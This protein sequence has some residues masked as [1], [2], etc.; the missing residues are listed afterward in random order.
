[1][2]L[3]LALLL[4]S[5]NPDTSVTYSG[6]AGQVDVRIPRIEADITVDGRLD[7]AAWSRAAILS[8]FSQFGPSDG[9]P[10]NDSTQVLVWYSPS[11]MYF[12]I[13]AFEAH[14]SVN[15]TMA[16]RDRIFSDDNIQLFLG[17]FHDG[18][19]AS[20]FAV[21]PLGVQADG[22][23]VEAVSGGTTSG[24][25]I[26]T[27]GG[28]EA[29]DLSP[30]FVFQSRGHLT[31]WGYEIEVRIPFKSLRYQAGEEQS[32]GLN[33]VRQVKH[34]GFE[35]SWTP[36]RRASSSFLGQSGT[37]VGLTGLR[38][39]LVMDV[40]PELTNRVTGA[41]A[42]GGYAYDVGNPQLGG[43]V[44]WGVSNNLTLN[45]S[46][47]PDFSQVE[48]DAGQLGF[49]PRL[50]LF[51]PEKRPFFLEGIEQFQVP[52]QLIY[53]RRIVQPVAAAKLTGKSFGT[54]LGF[55]AAVDDRS[56]SSTGEDNPTFVVFRAQR[57]VGHQSRLGFA[58]TD[59]R[60]PR[61]SNTLADIDG[62]L[63]F[64]GIY[65]LQ[66]QAAASRTVESG[67][68]RTAPLWRAQFDIN[69][70]TLG[71]TAGSTGI[72]DRFRADAGFIQRTGVVQNF[73]DPRVTLYGHPGG[74][75]QRLNADLFLTANWQYQN[76]VHGRRV[77]D[78][79]VHLNGGATLRGGWNFGL[80]IFIESFGYDPSLYGSYALEVPRAGGGLDTIPFTGQPTINNAEV[81]FQASTPQWKRFDVSAFGLKGND[82]NFFEWAS[83]DL[84]ILNV[85]VNWRPTDRMR[86]GMTYVWQQVNRRTDHTTVSVGRIPRLKLEYQIARPIFLRLVAQYVQ[87]RTDSLH[88]DSR[89]GAPILIAGP[90]GYTRTSVQADN[91]L[92]IDALF[93]YQPIPGTVVF[94]GY[95]STMTEGEAFHF[96]R[97]TRVVDGFFAK[98]SYL[99]RL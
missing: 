59:R 89:T 76:F 40:N 29:P 5:V 3:A 70:R 20:F 52:N 35:D 87:Q 9:V 88:D 68:A 90:G 4:Q 53:T 32:W 45:G 39:G 33:V 55:L 93:S 83:A 51:F 22:A 13:R 97:L 46:V 24:I 64:S 26:A 66:L 14:G 62:R 77:Q 67:T 21:N 99:F 48:S 30:D 95:G 47:K 50:A 86:I 96:D 44:R 79:K 15:A 73:L 98:V 12:G 34:S 94:A 16:D 2:M 41:P 56:A 19:Q 58:A 60:D 1:M 72:S 75:L 61:Y 11:A 82:E 7:E 31:A 37:L 71:F 80:G 49:D 10:A 28:R 36:A 85:A 27:G 42:S 92:Q 91:H 57:D 54:N 43:N 25:G 18:R 63:V 81:F 78:K 23:L 65:S 69:G 74:L 84:E 38:R 6:R 8:G 17:T